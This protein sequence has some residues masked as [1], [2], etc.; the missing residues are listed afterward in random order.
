[1]HDV[2]HKCTIIYTV[3]S[4]MSL[5]YDQWMCQVEKMV[6]QFCKCHAPSV[7]GDGPTHFFSDKGR[8][9]LPLGS[10]EQDTWKH[11]LQQGVPY[12]GVE[13]ILNVE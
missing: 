5:Q 12:I 6:Y 7:G 10:L 13:Y 2:S 8:E 4:M 9:W 1:M 3:A 11:A